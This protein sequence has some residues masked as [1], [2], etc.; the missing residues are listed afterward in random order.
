VTYKEPDLV[1]LSLD[2]IMTTLSQTFIA[3]D[4]PKEEE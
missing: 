2:W 1:R 4:I 3:Q